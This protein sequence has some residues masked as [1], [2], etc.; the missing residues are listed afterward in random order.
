MNKF[1]LFYFLN[2]SIKYIN[3]TTTKKEDEQKYQKLI[4]NKT[5]R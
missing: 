3:K 5:K 2:A 1:D 4:K